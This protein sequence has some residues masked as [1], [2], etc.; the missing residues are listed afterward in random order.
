MEKTIFRA[1][2]NFLANLNNTHCIP[3]AVNTIAG[4]LFHYHARGDIHLRMKEF[5]A[6]ASS[7]VLR[8]AQELEGHQDAVN[9]QSTLYIM[10]DEFV[11]KC[12]WLSMDV[13]EACL[14]YN[15]VRIAY[16][17]CYQQETDSF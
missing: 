13:L 3:L 10:L 1:E 16:Q 15:L 14:P 2:K 6:L 4:A 8:A 7:S 9:N 5:L 11:N 17:H 12:R